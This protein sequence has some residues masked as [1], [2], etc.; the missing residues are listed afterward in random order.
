MRKSIA[1]DKQ[2]VI[3][4]SEGCEEKFDSRDVLADKYSS[5]SHLVYLNI[6]NSVFTHLSLADFEPMT[7]VTNCVNEAKGE[8]FSRPLLSLRLQFHSQLRGALWI[9]YATPNEVSNRQRI[10]PNLLVPYFEFLSLFLSARSICQEAHTSF[11]QM[12]ALQIVSFCKK[13]QEGN[14]ILHAY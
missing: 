13:I 14:K 7:N 9:P 11:V 5:S 4:E 12:V 2:S 3:D 6:A 10:F 1:N 8:N